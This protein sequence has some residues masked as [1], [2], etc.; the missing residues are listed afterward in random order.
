MYVPIDEI[1][2]H[3]LV[4]GDVSRV[5]ALALFESANSSDIHVDGDVQVEFEP[6][7]VDLWGFERDVVGFEGFEVVVQIDELVFKSS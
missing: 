7:V 6:V 1:L 2:L 3:V 4:D 5:S